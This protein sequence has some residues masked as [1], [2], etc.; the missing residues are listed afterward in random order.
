MWC[1]N[2]VDSYRRACITMFLS[3]LIKLKDKYLVDVTAKIDT[4]AI[5]QDNIIS[6]LKL[7]YVNMLL[8]V[9]SVCLRESLPEGVCYQ[10]HVYQRGDQVR[11]I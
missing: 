6:S 1:D 7:I 9:Y 3:S 4:L 8:F 2:K 11:H 10:S 5:P